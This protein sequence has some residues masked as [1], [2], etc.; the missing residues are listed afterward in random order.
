MKTYSFQAMG[1]RILLAMDMESDD[2]IDLAQKVAEQFETW[3]QVFSRFRLTSELSELNRR[4]G[5]WI[6]VSDTFWEVFN[7]SI[8]IKALTNGLVRPDVLNEIEKAG[9][10]HSFDE[11][12]DHIDEIMQEPL[13]INGEEGEI[14]IDSVGHRIH[15]PFGK[16]IDLGGIVKGWAALQTMMQLRE[17][18]PVLVDAGGDISVSQPM[19]NEEPWPIGVA[20]PFEP[21]QNLRLVMMRQGGLATSGRDYRR[22][23]K[24]GQW[25]HHIIDPRIGRPA[26]TDI[27]SAT[28]AANDL[29]TAEA[30]AKMALILGTSKAR[31][32]LD[33]KNNVGYFFVMEDGSKMS[34]RYFD[35]LTWNEQWIKHQNPV[36]A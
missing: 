18:A 15:L 17:I 36:S 27:F 11:M 13:Q 8:K 2:F 9:Y 16:Q 24:G 1:S 7:L 31:T 10:V 19:Q 3:E 35:E 28:I 33:K 14:E 21:V 22:W 12:A 23:K 4:S 32:L 29:V 20:D 26:E 5:Q 25:Q 34:N 6:N 30:Y